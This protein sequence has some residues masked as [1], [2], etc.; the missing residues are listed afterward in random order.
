MG[1]FYMNKFICSGIITFKR[2]SKRDG[3]NS[4]FIVLSIQMP[5][6][7]R[8][9]GELSGMYSDTPAFTVSGEKALEFDKQ[10][11]VSDPVTIEG[12][13][14]TE[15]VMQRVEGH[16]FREVFQTALVIESIRKEE[17]AT[18]R[19]M[20]NFQG[21][22][23]WV[24]RNPE[25]GKQFYIITLDTV[26]PDGSHARA[27][28]TY[29]DRRMELEPQKGDIVSVTGAIR[30]KRLEHEGN[31]KDTILTTIVAS[32][33]TYLEKVP[34]RKAENKTAN[35]EIMEQPDETEQEKAIV[36]EPEAAPVENPAPMP[37]DPAS[38]NPVQE[39]PSVSDESPKED[40]DDF[41]DDGFIE[42]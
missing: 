41:D 9:S 17:G 6:P 31:A 19:N 2:L 3:V 25:S 34:R 32:S 18:Y 39:E 4:L 24:Y 37:E 28:T 42:L 1:G 26:L 29:F 40:S 36:E 8:R 5:K 12:H 15:R 11:A 23:S 38:E 13:V 10:F 27:N 35:K 21:K 14:D 30:V 16:M 7:I 33:V 22:V 20:V